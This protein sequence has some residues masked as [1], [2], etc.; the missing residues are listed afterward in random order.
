VTPASPVE[1]AV[2]G[3]ARSAFDEAAAEERE[4]VRELSSLR[5]ASGPVGMDGTLT[6]GKDPGPSLFAVYSDGR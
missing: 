5:P 1:A 6:V 3:A 2:R 4:L